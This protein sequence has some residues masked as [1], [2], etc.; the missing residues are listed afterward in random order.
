MGNDASV[1]RDPFSDLLR[2]ALLTEVAGDGDGA[3]FEG[4]FSYRGTA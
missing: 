3:A 1:D 2:R 4:L